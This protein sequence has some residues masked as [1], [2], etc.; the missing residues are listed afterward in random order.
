MSTNFNAPIQNQ[1]SCEK[2]GQQEDNL[3]AF[4][5]G[6][7]KSETSR[8]VG[9]KTIYTTN[10]DIGGRIVAAACNKC[11][12]RRWVIMLV[13]FGL[14]VIVG[15]GAALWAAKLNTFK[16]PLGIN[17]MALLQTVIG[18]GGG[19][20]GLIGLYGLLLNIFASKITH[21]ENLIIAV[22]KPEVRKLGFNTF[23][24]TKNFKKLKRMG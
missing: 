12:Q 20:L 5:F 4:H 19:I 6:K 16:G 7:K 24:N 14:M 1:T 23:W 13:V 8:H 22:K 2:C 10:F 17:Q 15:A 9:N 3:Y 11:I 18:G 21:A